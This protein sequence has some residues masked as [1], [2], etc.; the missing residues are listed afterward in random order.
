MAVTTDLPALRK[1]TQF[2]GHKADLGC[3]RCK[4]SAEREKGARGARGRMSY[5][6]SS[7]CTDRTHDEVVLQAQEYREAETKLRAAEIAQKNGVRYS[8]L[9]RLEYFDIVRMSATDP[10]HTFLLGLGMLSSGH[11]N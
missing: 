11:W 9:M 10:M 2:L 5:Y 7:R 3:S 8:E 6:T 4:F 1:V